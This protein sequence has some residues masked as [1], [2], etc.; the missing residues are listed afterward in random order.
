MSTELTIIE[1]IDQAEPRFIELAPTGMKFAA[2]KGYA[3]QLLNNN[4]YLKKA[5]EDN[6]NALLSAIVN[7]AAL[8]L[9]LNPAKKQAYLITR[10]IKQADGKWQTR[11]FLEPSYMGLCDIA[12]DTGVIEW[13][14]A[15][16]VFSN[17]KFTMN[18][19][20]KQ[21]DHAHDPFSA[22]R[23]EFVGAYCCVKL[24]NADRD[25]LTTPMNAA[26]IYA[27]R[28]RSEAYKAFL[29]KR[30]RT[31]GPWESDFLEMAK[32]TVVR[33]AFKM[34]PKNQG[35]TA[36]MEAAV[37][38]SNE[39]EGFEPLVIQSDTRK[40]VASERV[41]FHELLNADDALGL[42]CFYHNLDEG[43]RN[44]L[45]NDF[46]QGEKVSAKRHIS[47]LLTSGHN[48]FVDIL[49]EIE[50]STET[51]DDLAVKEL[52]ADMTEEVIDRIF[53]GLS[54]EAKAF[55]QECQ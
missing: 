36:R 22:D 29:D 19:L 10:N 35:Q 45:Y 27:I 31:G 8:G 12:T 30:A 9:S 14:Q 38:V 51:G 37:H 34:W 26:Q 44:N 17:D 40:A 49:A 39:N 32:K 5:A 43:P 47:E 6:P 11:V 3:A 55:V 48:Q 41:T 15:L 4:A 25:F 1:A 42:Y 24:S 50:T 20:D 23:G 13:I 21:P 53:T 54:S 28:D 2:E 52:I 33:N 16:A 46:P 18:G 7:L